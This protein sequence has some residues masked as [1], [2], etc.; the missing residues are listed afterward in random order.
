M[1]ELGKPIVIGTQNI[2]LDDTQTQIHLIGRRDPSGKNLYYVSEGDAITID[3]S[4]GNIYTGS[5]LFQKTGAPFKYYH[6][7]YLIHRC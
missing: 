7:I 5:V 1:W 6:I 3:G 4:T 2:Y